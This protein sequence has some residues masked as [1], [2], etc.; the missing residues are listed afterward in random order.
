MSTSEGT[1]YLLH[2]STPFKHARH[3]IGW[4]SN[5]A[6]R[7]RQHWAGHGSRLVRAVVASGIQLE[8]ART[9]AGDRYLERALKNLK[10]SPRLCPVCVNS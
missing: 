10:N 6:S 1:I 8:V 9:W 5:L 7:L 2:F 4:T 3:Y